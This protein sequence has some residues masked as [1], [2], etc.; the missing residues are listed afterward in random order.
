ML[1]NID[2]SGNVKFTFHYGPIQIE[3]NYPN[4]KVINKFTFHYGPI[5]IFFIQFTK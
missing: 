1:N 4:T 2:E 3:S 5:Q